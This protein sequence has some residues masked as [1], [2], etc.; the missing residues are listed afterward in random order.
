MRKLSP[1]SQARPPSDRLRIGDFVVDPSVRE[2]VAA[3]G[4]TAPVRITVKALGVLL[5]LVEHAGSV[6]SRDAL[7]EAVWPDTLP[8]EDVVTQ[9]IAQLRKAFGDSRARTA[10]IA[11]IS[12]RGYRLIA[13]VEWMAAEDVA[14]AVDGPGTSGG[15]AAPPDSAPARA[16]RRGVSVRPLRIAALLALLALLGLGYWRPSR[17]DLRVTLAGARPAMPVSADYQRIASLPEHERGPSL[18]PD[19]AM[20][21]YAQLRKAGDSS[22]LVVQTTSPL[23]ARTLTAFVPGRHDTRPAWSPDGQ[24]IAFVRL[25]DD[26]CTIVLIP[27]TGGSERELGPCIGPRPEV[28]RWFPDGKALIGAGR[29]A[30]ALARAEGNSIHRLWLHGGGWERIPYVRNVSDMDMYPTVSPDGRWIAF[31]RNLSVGDLWRMPAS[32]GVPERLTR[33]HF[34]SDGLAWTGDGRRLVLS[35]QREGRQVLSLLDIA[36]GRMSDFDLAGSH[37]AFPSVASKRDALVFQVVDIRER[38]LRLRLSAGASAFATAQTVVESSGSNW[39]PALA[40]D[41]RQL[42]FASDRTGHPLLWWI[43]LSV[44][45]SLHPIEGFVPHLS[46]PVDWDP[47]SRRVVVI[48]RGAKG[49]G[50]YEIEPKSGRMMFLGA[51]EPEPIQVIHH[52]DPSRLLVVGGDDSGRLRLTLYDRSARPWRVLARIEDDVVAAI[53]DRA[54]RRILFGRRSNPDI[55]QA[56]L[57]LGNVRVVDTL[58]MELRNRSVTPA[59]DGAWVMDVSVRCNWYWHRVGDRGDKRRDICLGREDPLAIDGVV[60]YDETRGEIHLSVLEYESF[61]IGYLPST[62]AFAVTE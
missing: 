48:G 20:V 22:A 57:E 4:E 44:P 21:A 32:G 35:R 16:S 33:L 36:S 54:R 23:P 2:I 39:I 62:D 7:L 1:R 46:Y 14:A 24:S 9:A 61:D 13:A 42:V 50:I 11:T 15:V 51:P 8:N 43:D 10:Y 47:T 53:V 41:D 5:M 45:E 17:V 38:I 58:E 37:L 49:K 19:G 60:A 28:I 31:H 27:A 29:T 34:K 30:E 26:V 59:A 25:S 18:S 55:M 52:P 6:V 3:D 12:K 56:D 40:P